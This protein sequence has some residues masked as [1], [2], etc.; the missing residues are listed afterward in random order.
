MEALVKMQIDIVERIEKAHKNFKKSPK[1]RITVPYLESRLESL[2]QLWDKFFMIHEQLVEGYA[3]DELGKSIYTSQQVYD[4]ADERYLD[5]KSELKT[6]LNTL[7]APAKSSVMKSQSS[8]SASKG[9]QVK[10]PKITIPTFSGLYTEW[11]S[12]RDLF[13]S[14]IHDNRDID[15]VQ[16]LHYLKGHLRGEAEQLLRHIPITNDSYEQ[17]WTLLTGRYNNKQYLINCILKRFF[18]QNNVV[19]ESAN[20]IKELL[21]VTSETLNALKSLGINIQSWDVLIIYIVS[22]RLDAESRKQWESKVSELVTTDSEQ[23]PTFTMFK[24]FL[25]TKYHSF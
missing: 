10:L 20:A 9:S 17:C 21:D 13:V 16:K 2:E 18:A 19:S 22:Q 6:I 3:K 24:D 25:E 23:L 4:N 14:L 12:F 8:S 1:D 7:K 15:N 11:M 5:Y